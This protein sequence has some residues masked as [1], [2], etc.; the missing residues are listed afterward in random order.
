[1]N[2]DRSNS[3]ERITYASM[4]VAAAAATGLWANAIG[5][6]AFPA[7]AGFGYAALAIWGLV[8][9]AFLAVPVLAGQALCVGLLMTPGG[10]A[11]SAVVPVLVGVILGAELT[12]VAD[13]LD[14][15]VRRTPAGTLRR[16]GMAG[17]V[18]A[19]VYT[20]AATAGGLPLLSGLLGT[21]LAAVGCVAVAL[22]MVR[23]GGA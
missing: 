13:R 22:L 2:E 21:G 1:M 15:P 16:L 23:R 7:V 14:S 5:G 10:P 9:P 8:N 11:P 4:A 12:A 19:A 17:V 18:G 3:R 6:P 20:V